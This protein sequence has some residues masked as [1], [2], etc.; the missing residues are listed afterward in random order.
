MLRFRFLAFAIA[1]TAVVMVGCNGGDGTG[2]FGTNGTNG[3]NDTVTFP[4]LPAPLLEFV[5]W[6][7][8][9]TRGQMVSG[10]ITETDCDSQDIDPEGVGYY[11]V[12]RVRV[13]SAGPVTFDANSGF[14]NWL[15]L[16]RLIS[17]D[18]GTGEVVAQWLMENDDRSGENFN[19]LIT[20]N[21][22]PGSDYFIAVSGYDYSETGSYTLTIE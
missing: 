18:E 8:N 13:A 19:A 4:N 1:L 22:Q 14:D 15:T 17:Y 9:A 20:Y 11:E 10:T 21:L 12:W 16:T 7:G 2:I 3:T 6:R 5:C